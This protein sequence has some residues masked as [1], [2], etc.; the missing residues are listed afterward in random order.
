MLAFIQKLWRLVKAILE[1]R[2]VTKPVTDALPEGQGGD[3]VSTTTMGIEAAN[4][5]LSSD[6]RGKA[7]I[8]AAQALAAGKGEDFIQHL[9]AH[10]WGGASVDAI[11]TAL[12]IAN[13]AGLPFAGIALKL[14]PLAIYMAQHPHN[15]GEDGIG[16][17]PAGSGSVP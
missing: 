2:R 6:P 3:V 8:A 13:A 16:A 12:T 7:I 14:L 17:D 9:Q 11:T 15:S 5:F 4:A 10:D 1:F